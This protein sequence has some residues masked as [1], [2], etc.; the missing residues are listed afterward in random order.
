[1]SN[2]RIACVGDI[3]CG[4]S[5]YNLGAGVASC[6]ERYGASFLRKEIVDF[7]CEHDAVLGNV[8]CSLSDKGR[9]DYALRSVHMR[10]SP[11]AAAYL[12][13]WGLTIANVANNHILEHGYDAAI[14][15]VRNLRRVG[16]K[17]IGTG[18]DGFFRSGMQ[19]EQIEFGGHVLAF[20]GMCLRRERYAYD[21]GSKAQEIIKQVKTLRAQ[22]KIVCISVHWGDEFMDRPSLE[23]KQMAHSLVEAG[24]T[25]VIGHHP[26][27][28]QGVE[29]YKGGLVAYSL[30]NFI[31]DSFLSDCR[32]SMILSLNLAGAEL[33][34]WDFVPIEMDEHHRPLLA[35]GNRRRELTKEIEHRCDLLESEATKHEYQKEYETDFSARDAQS[36]SELRRQLRRTS[37][38]M[39]PIY[40]PQILFRPIQRRL[41]I[42]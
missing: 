3:M 24:A 20:M 25:V 22:G 19:I 5:F 41:G 6:L 36:R 7:L 18:G 12:A 26:H 15:T 27:V 34:G 39:R 4:D 13:G 11:Q 14:D 16:I 9:K 29:R 35:V 2:I 37:L 42:W 38:Q 28:V 8:E 17:T 1:M 30:G 21:G 33:L 23:Q 10:G 40:W 32:W 31:F